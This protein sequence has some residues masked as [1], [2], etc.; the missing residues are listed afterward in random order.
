M[1]CDINA[2]RMQAVSEVFAQIPASL[3][4]ARGVLSCPPSK[5]F[6]LKPALVPCIHV[7]WRTAYDLLQREGS[8]GLE[9]ALEKS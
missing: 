1:N 3:E 2:S 8:G 6:P 4:S 9:K 7:C 5:C